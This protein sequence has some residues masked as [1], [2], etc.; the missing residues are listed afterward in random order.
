MYTYKMIQVPPNISVKAKDNKSGVAAAYL[1]G[2]SMSRLLKVGSFSELIPLV[3]K[4]SQDVSM[5]ERH[6]FFSTM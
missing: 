3:L 6:R 4:S 1:Q 2:W 5:A